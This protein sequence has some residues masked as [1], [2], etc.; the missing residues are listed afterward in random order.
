MDTSRNTI[1]DNPAA[2]LAGLS[3]SALLSSLGTSSANVALPALTQTFASSFQEVQWVVLAYLVAMT[4][5]IVAVG[6]LGD[7]LGRRRLLLAG[8]AL[9]TMASV[10]C[11]IAPTLPLLIAARAVQG[12]GAA[13]MMAL[14]MALV[15]ETIPKE[16]TGSAMGLL[17]TVSAIGT[18]LGPSLGGI[19]LATSGWRAIFLLN[20]PLGLAALLLAYRALP[21]RRPSAPIIAT[22][23]DSAGMLLLAMTLAAYSLA[24]TGSLNVVFML[25]ALVGAALFLRTEART[26]SPLVRLALF[27]HATISKG[28]VLSGLVT[29]V[30]MA[31]LVVGPFYLSDALGL[32]PAAVGAVMSLGPIVAHASPERSP[33][34]ST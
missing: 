4:T 15:G 1:L 19:I 14:A 29:T 27:R 10:L 25:A 34:R 13:A 12:V 33:S 20:V 11:A 16:R 17:G 2:V 24:M 9:F 22:R 7:L 21:A 6:R 32:P 18:A 23:F 26:A 5:V 28:F 8:L 31:T 3:L 30:V